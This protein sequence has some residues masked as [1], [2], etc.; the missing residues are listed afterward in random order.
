MEA[1][2]GI[3]SPRTSA[4]GYASE[5]ALSSSPRGPSR[6]TNDAVGALPSS[7]GLFDFVLPAVLVGLA[8]W[9][10]RPAAASSDVPR[11]PLLPRR[12]RGPLV[13]AEATAV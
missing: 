1:H 3:A 4:G 6:R 8:P 11:A 12:G 9:R 13:S 5:R 2:R 10:A 7:A